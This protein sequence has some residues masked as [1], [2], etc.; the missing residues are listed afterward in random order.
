[1]HFHLLADN[2]FE[3]DADVSFDLQLYEVL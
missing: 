3:S 1:L 2:A